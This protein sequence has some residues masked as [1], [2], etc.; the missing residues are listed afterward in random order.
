[1]IHLVP[2]YEDAY[3]PGH[4]LGSLPTAPGRWA[5]AVCRDLIVPDLGP[6][7]SRAGAG[8]VFDPAWDF[9]ADGPLESRVTR[10][11][12]VEGG[13]ALVRAA[14]EGVVTV[15]DAYGRARL[16]MPTSGTREVVSVVPIA[17]GSGST[18]YARSEN[19]FGR[20]CV[21]SAALLLVLL[22]LRV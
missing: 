16:A 5:V 13:F 21:V 15:S 17:A 20:A 4:E 8:L 18:P 12:A 22:G 19:L 11:R 10:L 7:L 1:K 2:G 9:G 14:K 3:L 6:R